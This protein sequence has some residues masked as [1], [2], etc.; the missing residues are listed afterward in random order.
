[1]WKPPSNKSTSCQLWL[2]LAQLFW[3]KRFLIFVNVFSLFRNYFPLEKGGVLHL[4]NLESPLPKDALCQ[5]WLNLALWFWRRRF[6]NFV[7][8]FSLLRT[9]PPLEKGR[10]LHLKKLESPA[11]KDALCQVWLTLAQWFWRRG[12]LYFVNE[13]SLFRTYPPWKRAGSFIW[14]NLITLHQGI[15][16]AKFGWNWPSGSGEEDENVKSLQTDG[17]TD[18]DDG[19]QVI[20]KANFSVQLRWA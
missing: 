20:R 1:M 10:A 3:R 14:G 4:N 8:V 2:K 16:C 9:Y 18:R 6:F 19:R 17:Q 15:L 5:V 12:F 7:N 11:P 13:F